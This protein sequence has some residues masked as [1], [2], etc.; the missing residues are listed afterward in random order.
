MRDCAAYDN[1]LDGIAIGVGGGVSNCTA[2]RNAR[3][4]IVAINGCTV[5]L[6]TCAA[7]GEGGDG[8]GILLTGTDNRVEQNNCTTNDRGI[9]VNGVGNVIMKNTCSGNTINWDIAVGNAVAPIVG[10]ATNAALISGNTYAGSLGST[11]PNANFT[12]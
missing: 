9:D 8:A 11:D 3:N 2:S 12:Y 10:A 6:N 7:N 4:G 1:N 5:F